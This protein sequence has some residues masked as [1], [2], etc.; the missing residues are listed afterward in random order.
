MTNEEH[1][2]EIE[3]LEIYA[4]CWNTLNSNK[5][6]SLLD[7][8]VEYN[9]QW[10]IES[11]KGKQSF[12]NYFNGKLQTLRNARNKTKVSAELKMSQKWTSHLLK[13]C[14]LITQRNNN[15]DQ[16]QVTLFIEVQDGKIT[17][18]DL[19]DVDFM[20]FDYKY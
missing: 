10:V 5:L 4:T 15:G 16:N 13:P 6:I 9:S 14:L 8:Q 7:E 11:L 12:L 1:K 2:T 20:F 19:C 3:I 17:R 18:I